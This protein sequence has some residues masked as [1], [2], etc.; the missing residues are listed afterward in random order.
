VSTSEHFTSPIMS[1]DNNQ[2]NYNLRSRRT[3]APAM[4]SSTTP[5]DGFIRASELL[6]RNDEE[7]GVDR[8]DSNTE[9]KQEEPASTQELVPD[10]LENDNDEGGS[11]QP[12]QGASSTDTARDQRDNDSPREAQGQHDPPAHSAV[13]AQDTS[14]NG[15]QILRLRVRV[16]NKYTHRYTYEYVSINTMI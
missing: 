16:W 2:P 6:R 11:T 3:I 1:N 12:T 5:S 14:D 8:C 4:S 15:P 7:R 9:D 10:I 13:A